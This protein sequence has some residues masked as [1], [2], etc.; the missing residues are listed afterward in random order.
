MIIILMKASRLALPLCLTLLT[1]CQASQTSDD[2]PSVVAAIEPLAYA[3]T[4]LAGDH[5]SVVDLTTPGVDAHDLELTPQQVAALH[6]A[7]LV[8]YLEGLQPAVDD[9]VAQGEL[10]NVLNVA[11]VLELHPAETADEHA[12]EDGDDHAA[13][14]EEEHA[15]EHDNNHGHEADPHFWQDP[16][17]LA[18]VSAQLSERLT[19]ADPEHRAD[20]EQ[21]SEDLLKSLTKLDEELESGLA[22][23]ER[24]EFITSHAAFGYLAERYDLVQL[25]IAGINP[26]SAPSPARIAQ[27]QDL[28]KEHGITTVFFET[29]TS[30]AVAKS[31][32]GD[33]DLATA[34][35]DPLAA[36]P[37]GTDYITGMQRNLEALRKAN[38]CQ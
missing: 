23:C 31:I 6:E 2:R 10:K 7:D 15:D 21:A 38:D 12:D 35:L 28:A 8:V 11:D 17:L 34:V 24:K 1:A 30:D 36:P 32:A 18:Q 26:N 3:A 5:W 13:D 9:I 37:E 20:Y 19:E 33:L 4:E 14:H 22:T 25:S 16:T 27:V 29:Q